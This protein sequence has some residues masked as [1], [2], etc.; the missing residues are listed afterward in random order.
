MKICERNKEKFLLV[1]PDP[2]LLSNRV[3][4]IKKRKMA[5]KARKDVLRH[6][7]PGNSQC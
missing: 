5:V 3:R 6:E 4:H 1:L 2:A 7:A